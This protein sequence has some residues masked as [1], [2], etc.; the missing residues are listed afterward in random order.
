MTTGLRG[1]GIKK[2]NNTRAWRFPVFPWRGAGGGLL[3]DQDEPEA[4]KHMGTSRGMLPKSAGNCSETPS[5]ISQPLF[6]IP[7]T[8]WEFFLESQPKYP[9]EVAFLDHSEATAFTRHSLWQQLTLYLLSHHEFGWLNEYPMQLVLNRWSICVWQ[10]WASAQMAKLQSC[11][12]WLSTAQTTV[13]PSSMASPIAT[14]PH[15]WGLLSRVSH[16]TPPH[17]SALTIFCK[18]ISV[19]WTPLHSTAT[20]TFC[21]LRTFWMKKR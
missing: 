15:P 16:G 4:A 10:R 18:P 9:H 5:C 2:R 11:S 20:H 1:D 13:A 12:P 3:A 8:Q 14:S 21:S 7:A 19:G 6:F 17:S